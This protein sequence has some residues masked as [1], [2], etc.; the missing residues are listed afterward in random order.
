MGVERRRTT[1]WLVAAIVATLGSTRLC[2]GEPG[3]VQ[4]AT[5]AATAE[6]D[7]AVAGRVRLVRQLIATRRNDPAL[8]AQLLQLTADLPPQEGA[9]AFE[10]LATV[11]AAAGE[12]NEA[13]EVRRSIVE[14]YPD[15][16]AALAA[17]RWLAALY[18]SSEV[19]FA[20]QPASAAHEVAD[21]G[22]HSVGVA[23]ARYA[24]SAMDQ[25]VQRHP[26]WADDP[27]LLTARAAAGRRIGAADAA[28]SWL[29]PLKRLPP[30]DPWGDAARMEG[31]LLD[32]GADEPPKALVPCPAAE[33]PVLDGVLADA[34]WRAATIVQLGAA[35]TTDEVRLAHDAEYLYVAIRAAALAPADAQSPADAPPR[36]HDSADRT[37]DHVRLLLDVDRDYATWFELVVD[38]R[39]HTAEGAWT[40]ASWNPEWFVAASRD[41]QRWQAE[42]AI[43]WSSLTVAAPAAGEAWAIAVQRVHGPGGV[44]PSTAEGRPGLQDP[45]AFTVLRFE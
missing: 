9:A 23:F 7:D 8:V 45:A 18:G 1:Q 17:T 34:C 3:G 28:L 27:Q 22:G 26:E 44:E 35:P 33:P 37:G 12:F 41:G 24:L 20:A 6:P 2:H 32:P 15:L 25:A 14:R 36:T 10:E 42:A 13:A 21:E 39:G 31:W 19:A 16:P 29:R 4:P 38:P 43:P 40:D 5:Y 30:G 11:R